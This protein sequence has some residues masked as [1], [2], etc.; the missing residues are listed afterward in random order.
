ME[1]ALGEQL[2]AI[3]QAAQQ[4]LINGA[5]A[6]VLWKRARRDSESSNKKAILSN[7]ACTTERV[8]THDFEVWLFS[9]NEFH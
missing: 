4:G 3:K 8:E 7:S 9:Y 5:Q 6:L 2:S 1:H